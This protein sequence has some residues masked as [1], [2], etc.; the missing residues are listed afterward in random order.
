MHLLYVQQ[1][2][3][4]PGCPGNDRCW[5]FAQQWTQAGHQVTFLA[6]DA[7]LPAD[8]PLRP[9]PPP[10]QSVLF[11]GVEIFFLPVPYDHLF[12]FPRR[13][14]SFLS[15]FF[16]ARRI[17]RKLPPVEAIL[18]Y[19]APLSVAELGRWLS[20]KLGLPF[21][22]EVADVWPEVP[23]GMGV[24]RSKSLAR[25]LLRRSQ[26]IYQE[27]RLIFPYSPGMA[28]Q[29]QAHGIDGEKVRVVYNGADLARV[30]F[31]PRSH[32]ASLKLIYTGTIGL[33]NDLTQVMDALDH[34]ERSGFQAW[35]FTVIGQGNDSNRVQAHTRALGL[36][37]V[38]FR[39]RLSREEAVQLLAE[40]DVGVVS[41]APYP[42]LEAN[43]ATKFFD[44]L[45]AGL[46][47]L[48]NYRG[49]QADFL[50]K[51]EAGLSADQG[52]TEGLAKAILSLA[53]NPL[54][55]K[56]MGENGRRLAEEHF[57]RKNMAQALLSSIE[58][59]LRL[60]RNQ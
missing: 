14:W 21:Y 29:I 53:Q 2:L 40:A 37:R 43:S 16:Q 6:S 47:V 34:L 8:H 51:W 28:Q 27:A 31:V 52:D 41:F 7:H 55:R 44:Y 48:I 9:L 60:S 58:H 54:R 20:R 19:T 59:D 5:R 32:R 46:P 24:I 25:M 57:D 10:G 39:P 42:V 36:S 12:P 22:L 33:A 30:H 15:F 13:V 38:A 17:C 35:S 11:Q 4:L 23:I 50:T 56:S 18:A 45:A 1:L 49:W 3:V 26:R